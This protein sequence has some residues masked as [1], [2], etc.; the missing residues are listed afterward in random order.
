MQVLIDPSGKAFPS[1]LIL[2]FVLVSQIAEGLPLSSVSGKEAG[3]RTVST[4]AGV[5][6]NRQL[7][8]P[9]LT[10]NNSMIGF[11][12]EVGQED[13]QSYDLSGSG[14]TAGDT[15]LIEVSDASGSFTISNGGS[16]SSTIEIITQ[17]GS[18]SEMVGVKYAPTGTG[19]HTASIN[20]SN[21]R[22][23]TQTVT[24]EGNGGTLPVEW[25]SFRASITEGALVLDWV[26]ASEKN[27]SHFE[28]ELS[29]NPIAGFE[30]IGRVESK[31]GN[32][33]QATSYR[34]I[35]N[36]RNLRG[37]LYLRLKQVDTDQVFDYSKVIA[38]EGR[39]PSRTE[40]KVSPN[41]VS[42]SAQVR[43][44]TAEAGRLRLVVSSLE[45]TPLFSRTDELHTGENQIP[46]H[47]MDRLPAGMYLLTTEFAGQLN[48]Q[49]LIKE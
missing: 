37:T 5:S 17:D 31:V 9:T 10:I 35:Y 23:S 41:P 25:H 14:F 33:L 32:S 3:R 48:R 49:R 6:T 2:L 19:G 47:L 13:I 27:N 8:L 40:V 11:A 29:G 24:V 42:S 12:A 15:L 18:F 38:V 46:L 36:E 20:H 26:T 28:I 21:A 4:F 39:A 44:T 22:I 7:S 45:G 34:F 43:I 1:L 30:K 16:Y